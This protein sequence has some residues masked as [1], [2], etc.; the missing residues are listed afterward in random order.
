MARNAEEQK[1]PQ[2]A[3]QQY[4]TFVAEYPDDPSTP[5][6]LLRIGSLSAAAGDDRKGAAAYERVM[7]RFPASPAADDAVAGAARCYEHMKDFDRALQLYRE[8]IANYPDS[9]FRQ[10]AERRLIILTTFEAKEKDAGLEKLALLVGDVVA[11]KDRA[12][13]AFRLGE[14]YFNDLKNYPAAA[15]QFGNALE[16]GLPRDRAE[17]AMYLKARSLEFQSWKDS[18]FTPR[19]IEAYRSLLAASPASVHADDARLALFRLC[20]TTLAQTWEAAAPLIADSSVFPRKDLVYLALG[21]KLEQADSTGAALGAYLRAARTT[22]DRPVAEE[23]GYRMF[24]ILARRGLVDSA[25]TAGTSLLENFPGGSHAA[26]T[27]AQ[28]AR[29]AMS[30]RQQRLAAGWYERLVSQFGYTRAAEGARRPLADALAAAGDHA[31]ALAAYKELYGQERA[32]PATDGTPEPGLLIA[33][34]NSSYAAGTIPEAK[35]WLIEAI[36]HERTGPEAGSAFT[37]LGFIARN[38]GSH[39]AI[40]YF[41]QAEAAAP[42]ISMTPDVAELLFAGGEYADA[43]E[44]Y[45]RLAHDAAT[46]SARREYEARV[47]VSRFRSDNAAA[48]EKDA[49]VFLKRYPA[50]PDERAMFELEKGCS[51]FR[52][53][54]YAAAMKSFSL[55]TEKFDETPSALQALYWTGKTLEATDKPREAIQLLETIITSHPGHPIVPRVHFALGNLYYAVEQ[56]NEAIKHYR[57]VV[58]DSTVEPALHAPAMS[59]LIETYEAAGAN[60]GAL[61]LTRKYL[62][63]Y[64]NSDDAFDKRIKIGILYSRL[65]YYDQAVVHL[66][67]LL[68]EAGSDLEGEI[69]YYIADAYYNKGEYQQAILDFLKVPYLVTK[70]GKIDWTANALYMSGQSYEK[71]GRYDQALTMYQ[72]IVDR[73]GIDTTFKD[74]ARKEIDRVRTVVQQKPR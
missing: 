71:M 42:G 25:L 51:L 59:N 22:S 43:A 40:S 28:L 20:A 41:R 72:Q 17:D 31:A 60:D 61:S 26:E 18:A 44:H 50:T 24:G 36:R 12:G 13:L 2:T 47:I 39:D 35:R 74:A 70:K 37:A 5:G 67:S 11:E 14:I 3:L 30:S 56:W 7:V 29:L 46:D 34:G 33:L 58:E 54:D 45:A 21:Q 57:S 1:N 65:G 4:E 9:D 69:R 53:E 63:L 23:S 64:P 16:A 68:D 10:E 49:A 66:Q 62:E 19:A 8:L 73:K 38:E 55:V 48:A 27:L 6:M 15:A 32:D 52:R